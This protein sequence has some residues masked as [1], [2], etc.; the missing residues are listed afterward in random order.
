MSKGFI[1]SMKAKG[2]SQA[3][4]PLSQTYLLFK[5][6][7]SISAQV[8][9]GKVG[10]SL[11][12]VEPAARRQGLGTQA[13][14]DLAAAA[15]ETGTLLTLDAYAT[16]PQHMPLEVLMNFYQKGGFR[17]VGAVING[18]QTFTRSP[19]AVSTDA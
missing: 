6:P 15:D 13:L 10:I 9:S 14:N 3:G 4:R 19:K 17:K 18:H 2:W 5:G 12:S 11:I 8:F 16:R 1:E 7:A